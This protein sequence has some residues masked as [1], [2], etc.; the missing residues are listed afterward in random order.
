MTSE[1]IGAQTAAR[2]TPT[3]RP[4]S[5]PEPLRFTMRFSSTPRGARLARRMAEHLLDAWGLP[6]DSEPHD[7]LTLVVAELSAN[8]VQHGRVA[9]RD[10]RLRLTLSAAGGRS[11]VRV[12]V[13]DTRAERLP[14][15][16][17]AQDPEHPLTETGRGL[18]L[19]ARLA[20]DWGWHPRPDGPGKTVWA[21]C[22]PRMTTVLDGPWRST[23]NP[24]S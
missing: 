13:T 2:P 19:V 22:S 9:G 16:A 24:K 8:A 3:T 6:Y 12:E 14:E 10:F 20:D 15:P 7:T 18:L 23:A 17:P 11:T 5:A 1:P 21:E 4:G